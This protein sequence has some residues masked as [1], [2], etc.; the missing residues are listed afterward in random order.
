MKFLCFKK[1]SLSL[2]DILWKAG[3]FMM[4]WLMV[5]GLKAQTQ[6]TMTGLGDGQVGVAYRSGSSGKVELKF[7]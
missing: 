1:L 2:P 4:R 6:I 3:I 7:S 5:S